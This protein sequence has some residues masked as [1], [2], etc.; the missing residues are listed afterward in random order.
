MCD[1]NGL[2]RSQEPAVPH[3]EHSLRDTLPPFLPALHLYHFISVVTLTTNRTRSGGVAQG[4]ARSPNRRVLTPQN[5]KVQQNMLTK[6]SKVR[7]RNSGRQLSI[8]STF[9]S[10]VPSD[11][12][13]SLTTSCDSIPNLYR[14]Q[15]YRTRS[16]LK[17]KQQIKPTRQPGCQASLSAFGSHL[18]ISVSPG[19]RINPQ[20]LLETAHLSKGSELLTQEL[21]TAPDQ[22]FI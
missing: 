5:L 22:A 18:M 2:R 19:A 17:Q 6:Y 21:H 20:E 10:C 11:F 4:T 16:S 13:S 15:V 1:W 3:A 8:F 12:F 7:H 14:E 9:S